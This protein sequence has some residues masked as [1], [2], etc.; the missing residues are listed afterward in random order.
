MICFPKESLWPLVHCHLG[1]AG[2]IKTTVATKPPP[3]PLSMGEQTGRLRGRAHQGLSDHT[4]QDRVSSF[5]TA[6]LP[7]ADRITK[8]HTLP[9]QGRS[10]E[11]G[12][13][14]KQTHVH[15]ALRG[16]MELEVERKGRWAMGHVTFQ[17]DHGEV[18]E[19]ET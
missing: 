5:P 9:P 6:V 18:Q 19:R 11:L 3:G 7:R 1:R 16:W 10:R 13:T 15:R 17:P 4:P 8:V 2:S 12:H 14:G